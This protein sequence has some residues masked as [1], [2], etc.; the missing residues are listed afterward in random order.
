MYGKYQKLKDNVVNYEEY[1]NFCDII[2]ARFY[3]I[4]VNEIVIDFELY[5]EKYINDYL[6]KKEKIIYEK[7]MKREFKTLPILN[8]EDYKKLNQDQIKHLKTNYLNMV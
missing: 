8:I 5:R 2:C 4:N 6:T 3:D 7:C 1:L